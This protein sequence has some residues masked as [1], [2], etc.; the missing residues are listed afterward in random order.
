[1]PRAAAR[2]QCHAPPRA[3]ARRRC[4][5]RAAGRRHHWALAPADDP[6]RCRYCMS[7]C[8]RG[9]APNDRLAEKAKAALTGA[10]K[11][12]NI[13]A[14]RAGQFEIAHQC[15]MLRLDVWGQLPCG[16]GKTLDIVFITL[17]MC[18]DGKGTIVIVSEP[19]HGILDMMEEELPKYGI[20]ILVLSER[21]RKRACQL[22]IDSRTQRPPTPVAIVGHPE[23]LTHADFLQALGPPEDQR[24]SPHWKSVSDVKIQMS[25]VSCFI[26]DEAHTTYDKYNKKKVTFKLD[27]A[28]VGMEL[29][30]VR[31]PSQAFLLLK[32]GSILDF[33]VV[34]RLEHANN[35]VV[36]VRTVLVGEKL[37]GGE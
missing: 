5:A 24:G 9:Q 36:V 37:H 1:M 31:S 4:G 29:L 6:E 23:Q 14:F 19:L 20:D 33:A 32:G 7:R 10:K 28:H 2:C 3:A 34:V 18:Q 12:L 27:G 30:F 15:G 26:V 8:R 35:E 11:L 17:L 21:T 22:L 25:P 16:G 13:D